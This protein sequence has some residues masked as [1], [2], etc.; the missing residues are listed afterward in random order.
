M[1]NEDNKTLTMAAAPNT[2]HIGTLTGIPIGIH[3]GEIRKK[4]R[5]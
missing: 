3:I 4:K 5:I 1:N 2:I